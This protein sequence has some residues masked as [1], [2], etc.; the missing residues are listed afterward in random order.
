MGGTQTQQLRFLAINLL[1]GGLSALL[2]CAWLVLLIVSNTFA[3][4]IYVAGGALSLL[5][6]F[7]E[8]R[9]RGIIYGLQGV[10]SGLPIAL[11][12][13]QG[14]L[15]GKLNR[16]MSFV[17]LVVLWP[18]R[19]LLL[20]LSLIHKTRNKN[21]LSFESS[22]AVLFPKYLLHVPVLLAVSIVTYN[23]ISSDGYTP[24]AAFFT[25]ATT[26]CTILYMAVIGIAS[27]REFVS[28]N[29]IHPVVNAA[30]IT[31]Q[32]CFIVIFV[33]ADLLPLAQSGRHA[34]TEGAAQVFSFSKLGDA[35]EHTIVGF[36]IGEGSLS[37]ASFSLLILVVI[38][39]FYLTVIRALLSGLIIG[40]TD[41]GKLALGNYFRSRGHFQRANDIIKS[42]DGKNVLKQTLILQIQLA[43]GQDAGS[44]ATA[45]R[46]LKLIDAEDS[47]E[48]KAALVASAI[49]GALLG[50][51]GESKKGFALA[52]ISSF[53]ANGSHD[54][55]SV[56]VVRDLYVAGRLSEQDLREIKA[57]LCAQQ[58]GSFLWEHLELVM[59][60]GASLQQLPPDLLRVGR[61]ALL[62]E[63][64]FLSRAV[65]MWPIFVLGILAPH[66]GEQLGEPPQENDPLLGADEF[67][68]TVLDE[69]YASRLDR[70]LWEALT[71]LNTVG[72]P[73]KFIKLMTGDDGPVQP[74]HLEAVDEWLT[75]LSN[76]GIPGMAD[77]DLNALAAELTR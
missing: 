70:K 17:F 10:A 72:I 64:D 77:M 33:V 19:F 13:S 22:A 42:V 9:H 69:A 47:G 6:G 55:L 26:L 57:Q 2:L 51:T 75:Q 40:R 39:L 73:I 27:F 34:F 41:S 61:A 68:R 35:V 38:G 16:L 59:L 18:G 58:P 11:G 71:L 74:K 24:I 12:L 3:L 7:Y 60:I 1:F 67:V 56:W 21:G 29:L 49:G 54:S 65:Y 66:F 28:K 31:A 5:H 14:G 63:A 48:N 15:T 76:E 53:R 50:V 37:A 32:L 46:M 30:L 52:L 25:F 44:F 20:A 62:Q 43:Q 45:A 36:F 23:E 4:R 8:T